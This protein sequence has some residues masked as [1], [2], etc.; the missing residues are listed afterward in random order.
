MRASSK[1]VS[2]YRKTCLHC[3]TDVDMKKYGVV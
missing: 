2:Y 3:T 1:S